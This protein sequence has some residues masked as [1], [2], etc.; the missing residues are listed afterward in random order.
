[1][2]QLNIYEAKS[3]FSRLV[4]KVSQGESVVIAKSGKP[5]AQLVPLDSSASTTFQ[6][7]TLQGQIKVA[8]D[9]DAPLPDEVLDLFEVN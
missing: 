7:G 6:F 1:M 8:D 2:Q 5:L 3:H 9:F 4:E